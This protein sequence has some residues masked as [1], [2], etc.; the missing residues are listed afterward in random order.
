MVRAITVVIHYRL[1]ETRRWY[2]VLSY[3]LECDTHNIVPL[4][5]FTTD[6]CKP[7][8]DVV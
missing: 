3:N 1:L 2:V 7:G 6:F 5:S 4:W 8:D